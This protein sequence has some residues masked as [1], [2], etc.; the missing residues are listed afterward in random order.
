[1]CVC[2]DCDVFVGRHCT[3]RF[4]S[5]SEY[6]LFPQSTP[7]VDTIYASA[8]TFLHQSPLCVQC[9]LLYVLSLVVCCVRLFVYECLFVCCCAVYCMCNPPFR[10]FIISDARR[11]SPTLFA[12]VCRSPGRTEPCAVSCGDGPL[13]SVCYILNTMHDA[14]MC[15]LH[16]PC[17]AL[18]VHNVNPSVPGLVIVLAGWLTSFFPHFLHSRSL[19]SPFWCL[20]SCA[21]WVCSV[22]VS[23]RVCLCVPVCTTSAATM[24]ARHQYMFPHSTPPR[25]GASDA[26]FL[27]AM[28]RTPHIPLHSFVGCI[29]T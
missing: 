23:A 11:L 16:V 2:C 12:Y 6:S 19:S 20:F 13:C 9:V 10:S 22:C 1:M 28:C 8:W 7:V 15:I 21:T 29:C 17:V 24:R 27:F 3:V 4:S 25:L 18:F 26:C 5:T 14:Y